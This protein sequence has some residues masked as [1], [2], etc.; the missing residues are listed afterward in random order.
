MEK[1][2]LG[3][4]CIVGF[5]DEL[6]IR[7][8]GGRLGAKE[9]PAAF[10]EAFGRVNGQTNI[11]EAMSPAV[12]VT[13]SD[14]LEKNY[15]AAVQE[16]ERARMIT[17]QPKETLVVVGGGHD[18]AYPWIRGIAQSNKTKKKIGCLNIDAHFDLREY[19]AKMTSGSP[20]RRLIEEKWLNSAYLVEF[21]IQAHCNVPALWDY[22][23]EKKIKIIPFE[24]LRNGQAVSEFKKALQ[25]LS[26]TCDEVM[27][28]VDLDALSF[29]YCPGVSAPQGEGFT[30][31]EL[32]QMLEIAGADKKVTSLGIFELS[33]PLDFQN[34]TSRLAAQ[35]TW[36]FLHAKNR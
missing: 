36:H 17:L 3:N 9:G 33:P 8:V 15:L 20:F 19:E 26:K 27:L 1:K 34:Y 29:A 11:R 25:A 16:V 14:D 6:G 24:K 31:S 32:Y 2:N 7:N 21:G 22:A 18:Y 5:P 30:G 23:A 4:F 35:A 28:S 10:L 13:M 12:L